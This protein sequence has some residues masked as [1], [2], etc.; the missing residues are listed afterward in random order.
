MGNPLLPSVDSDT[1]LPPSN[2]RKA[3]ADVLKDRSSLEG[4]AIRAIATVVNVVDYGA[5]GD[6]A[7]DDTA[8]IQ[9]AIDV[10]A[11]SGVSATVFLPKGQFIVRTL[12]LAK[13]ISLRGSGRDKTIIYAKSGDGSAALLTFPTGYADHVFVD[14]LTLWGGGANNPGQHGIYAYARSADGSGSSSGWGSGGMHRVTIRNFYGDALWLR[15]GGGTGRELWQ[16]QFLVLDQVELIAEKTVAASAA[17]RVSGK[18]GQVTYNNVQFNTSAGT[19]ES[20]GTNLVISTERDDSGTSI[21]TSSS[22]AHTFI[23]CSVEGRNRGVTVEGAFSITF[24]GTFMEALGFGLKAMTDSRGITMV[25]THF[26][27]AGHTAA[28]AGSLVEGNGTSTVSVVGGTV[29]GAADKSFVGAVSTRDVSIDPAISTDSNTGQ[30]VVSS[31]EILTRRYM[32][33]LVNS[34]ATLVTVTSSLSVGSSLF[35]K[36]FGGALTVNDSG[37]ISLGGRTSPVTV[38]QNAILQLVRFDLS[39]KWHLVSVSA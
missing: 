14:D 32:T 23:N 26:A 39:G 17:L 19:S 5:K 22:Y 25:G 38:P 9:A 35:I 16:H 37:N 3:N 2:V 31:G 15:G 36:A 11:S 12:R 28:A 6:G 33:A 20:A 29:V 30:F 34:P 18:V 10:A 13:G 7:N 4:A 21:S 8:A 1:Y 24:V 27:N